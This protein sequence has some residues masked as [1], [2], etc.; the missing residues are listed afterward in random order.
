MRER[1]QA[2]LLFADAPK[3]SQAMGFDNQKPHNQWAKNDLLGVG[4][5]RRADGDACDLAQER[6]HLVDHDGQ[7]HDEGCTKEAA[8]DRAHAAQ[9]HHE[10]QLKRTVHG[11]SSWLPRTEVNKGPQ[12]TRHAHNERADRK[13]AELGVHGTNAYDSSRHVQDY[14]SGTDDP[15]YAV[16]DD[17]VYAYWVT[18]DVAS[19]KLEF[20]KKLLT[21]DDTVSPTVMFTTPGITVTNAVLEYTKERIV[22][23]INNK[24]YEISTTATTLP[25]A[26]YTH[27]DNDVVFAWLDVRMPVSHLSSMP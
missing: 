14:T 16:C 15:V 23:A 6:Q 1:P 2:Q 21:D 22:A 17:G 13:R 24:I 9:D 4:Q 12:C 7:H 3:L 10:Q 18:N 26:V 5:R 19:G 27:P 20:N 11:E 8:H 25:T